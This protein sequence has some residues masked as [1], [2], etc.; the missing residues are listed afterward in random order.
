MNP[1]TLVV[2]VNL[3]L[4]RDEKITSRLLK[5]NTIH[6]TQLTDTLVESRK[7]LR[8]SQRIP[9]NSGGQ[10]GG[11]ELKPERHFVEANL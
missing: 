2:R 9:L 10:G 5:P 7:E 3:I 1:K 8:S 4:N 11:G 6:I